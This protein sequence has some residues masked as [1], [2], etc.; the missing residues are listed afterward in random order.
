VTFVDRRGSVLGST[1]THE[2][3]ILMPRGRGLGTP[4][5]PTSGHRS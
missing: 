5:R 3:L 1:V 2:G 4:S